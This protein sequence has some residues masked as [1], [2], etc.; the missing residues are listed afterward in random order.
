MP[1]EA[2]N[3]LP[4]NLGYSFIGFISSDNKGPALQRSQPIQ[5]HTSVGEPARA[6]A[7]ASDF[8]SNIKSMEDLAI[9]PQP[10]HSDSL[11]SST[12]ARA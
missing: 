12:T 9:P 10:T 8:Q 5:L 4:D 2:W 3:I 1:V 7:M 11:T 6:N